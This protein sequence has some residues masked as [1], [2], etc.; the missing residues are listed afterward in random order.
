MLGYPML[1]PGMQRQNSAELPV[2]TASCAV[3][4]QSQSPKGTSRF[5]AAKSDAIRYT[6]M[7][8]PL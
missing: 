5:V 2:V 1:Q 7:L 3:A 4:K 6:G 8:D